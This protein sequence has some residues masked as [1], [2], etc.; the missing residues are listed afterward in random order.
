[1]KA[2]YLIIAPLILSGC[3]NT[4]STSDVEQVL[5]SA[6]ASCQN[7]EVAKINKT[8]GYEKDG[9]YR[10][11]YE[12]VLHLKNKEG[13]AKLKNAWLEDKAREAEF[14]PARAEYERQVREVESE[15]AKIEATFQETSPYREIPRGL[16]PSAQ[17]EYDAAQ[18]QWQDERA[19]ATKG[20]RDKL[21]E[22]ARVW[23]ED[24]AKVPR[25]QVLRNEGEVMQ[26]FFSRG[27]TQAG[28]KY[29]SGLF[30]AHASAVGQEVAKTPAGLPVDRSSWFEEKT[31]EMTGVMTMHKT[32]KGWQP[33]SQAM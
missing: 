15:I 7:I 11:E 17:R 25:S 19:A 32:E 18:S 9:Y 10:V 30:N 6:V 26:A 21:D 31:A 23:K 13:L 16:S 27:C 22:L 4:P 8:N 28:W 3:S 29:A 20:S 1:M 5:E 2:F 12:Y 14:G 33:V 24:R